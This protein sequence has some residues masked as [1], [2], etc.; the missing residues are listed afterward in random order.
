MQN[1]YIPVS[2][3]LYDQLELLAMR[4]IRVQLGYESEHILSFTEGIIQ[5]IYTGEN[6]VEFLK[7]NNGMVIRLDQLK[8]LNGEPV[9]N[10]C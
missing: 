4:K 6:H 7:L 1:K 9:P 10:F 3:A 2:C 8:T 5:D